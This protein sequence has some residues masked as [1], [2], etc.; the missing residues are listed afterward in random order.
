[1]TNQTKELLTSIEEYLRST[2]PQHATCSTCGH[3]TMAA[4]SYCPAPGWAVQC[5]RCGGETWSI[6]TFCPSADPRIL[7]S[8]AADLIRSD[9]ARIKAS[10]EGKERGSAIKDVYASPSP[11]TEGPSGSSRSPQPKGS[12]Q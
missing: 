2:E 9:P 12:A 8:E 5:P 10:D 11:V 1:M 4:S 3:E 6:T 7:L